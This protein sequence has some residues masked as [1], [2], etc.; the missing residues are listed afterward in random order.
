MRNVVMEKAIAQRNS[1]SNLMVR[2]V[3]V[4]TIGLSAFLLFL[5]Q[6]LFSK[7]ALPLLGGSSIVWNTA[8][9]FFQT[10]LLLGYL[11]AHFL[12]RLATHKWQVAIHVSI[13][14]TAFAFLPF[15]IAEWFPTPSG[16]YAPF[17]LFGLFL[18]SIG[19]PFFVISAN[20]PLIQSWFSRTSHPDASNPYF[21][22]S[23]SNFGSALALLT[24]PLIVEPEFTLPD[25]ALIWA[26]G[27]FVLVFL[28]I[29]IGSRFSGHFERSAIDVSRADTTCPGEGP[30][31]LRQKALWVLFG[32][33]PAAMMLAVTNLI[34]LDLVSIPLFWIAPLLIYLITFI[35][36]FSDHPLRPGSEKLRK[37]VHLAAPVC[38]VVALIPKSGIAMMA[39]G[40]ALLLGGFFVIALYLH[41]RLA[42]SRPAANDLTKFYVL[43]SL[44]GVLGGASVSLLA[45]L[46]FSSA[47]EILWLLVLAAGLSILP[48]QLK[49]PRKFLNQFGVAGTMVFAIFA[50]LLISDENVVAVERSYF[51][52][53]KIRNMQTE[54]GVA[55]INLSHGT[56]MHGAQIT[57][58]IHDFIPQTYYVPKSGVGTILSEAAESANIAIVG[59]GAGSLSCYAKPRQS[60]TYFEIDPTVIRIAQDTRYFRFIDHCKP[61]TGFVLGDAR[62]SLQNVENGKFDY[63]VIDAFSSDSIPVHLLTTEAISL[64]RQKL[65]V[66]GVLLLHVSNRYF[67]LSPIL[68]RNGATQG[69]NVF[70]MHYD[71]RSDRTRQPIAKSS[72]WIAMTNQEDIGTISRSD[73]WEKLNADSEQTPWTDHYSDILA[74]LKL[75]K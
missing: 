17:M 20:A 42:E 24:Y 9:L 29:E 39:S 50:Y 35:I 68:A 54:D 25:Q 51:G 75:L 2:L 36:A 19:L 3:F 65:T 5:I 61:D 66:D 47:I 41:S 43:Q 74:T 48:T 21:L 44:G 31:S 18:V 7:M 56:T 60:W 37:W 1:Q 69:Y 64:Y 13:C 40:I 73:R 45:P 59:L 11:Y 33:V 27:F 4:A 28:L 30:V 57:D 16:D 22:Y 14:L 23:A 46:I 53:H 58:G 6:P 63:L 72:I 8:M 71:A 52:V 38:L 32:L 10:L 26:A 55:M 15:G 62:I 67:E 12:V 49:G 34:T 70:K